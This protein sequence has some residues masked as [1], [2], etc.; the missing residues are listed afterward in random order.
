MSFRVY[1]CCSFVVLF[2]WVS[3]AHDFPTT[4]LQMLLLA[5]D[6]CYTDAGTTAASD[7]QSV[8]RWADLSGNS[9]HA[10]QS[11]SSL[12]PVWRETWWNSRPA[13]EFDGTDDILEVTS[14]TTLNPATSEFH[15]YVCYFNEDWDSTVYLVSKGNYGS[16]LDEG[17]AIYT[18]AISGENVYRVNSTGDS[19]GRAAQKTTSRIA[20]G[21]FVAELHIASGAVTATHYPAL[22]MIDGGGG[23]TG[24][25]FAGSI[26]NSDSV[27]IGG[28]LL[29]GML[30]VV[31]VY[32]GAHDQAAVRAALAGYCQMSEATSA[33]GTAAKVF[34]T[35][36]STGPWYRIPTILQAANGDLLAFAER[37]NT[38][39]DD[40][41]NNDI[42]LSVSD[43]NGAT[44][45]ALS[46]LV[47]NGT[48]RA[49]DP[50]PI[51]GADGTVYLLYAKGPSAATSDETWIITSDDN[52][53]TWSSEV[54][55]TADLKYAG[56]DKVTP[57]PSTGLCLTS[58]R[59]VFACRTR[60]SDRATQENRTFAAYSDDS[61]STWAAGYVLDLDGS[62]E[63]VIAPLTDDTLIMH[64][65]VEGDNAQPWQAW[66]LS[67]DEGNSW[68]FLRLAHTLPTNRVNTGLASITRTLVRTG[69]AT[70]GTAYSNS[71]RRDL[72]VYTS[73][74]GEIWDRRSYIQNGP[75][76]YS[77]VIE[78]ADNTAG[79]LY[80]GDDD[81]GTVAG[82]YDIFY[83]T[84]TIIP[85]AAVATGGGTPAQFT[86]GF[87]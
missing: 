23:A 77:Q 19:S 64:A 6:G 34:D 30:S 59:L 8:Y 49:A 57:L 78:V 73:P 60:D 48:D 17:W 14:S 20:G 33:V 70:R 42:V 40:L 44:W 15:V 68:Q 27:R 5:D 52:G 65:R 63:S 25:T 37:R 31:A 66:S 1:L 87:N 84:A 16:S 4:N 18:S 22:T 51:L 43:D 41:G 28:G 83:R 53:A 32:K 50:C 46:V 7:G 38:S 3:F 71:D 13:V 86:G 67:F 62:N 39:N 80:E 74:T 12:R 29:D 72:F 36:T 55:I 35:T 45:G 75:I 56:W 21:P 76:G 24:A 54:E 82:E 10:N 9:N 26:D 61:G 85:N 79:I 2:S 58:G 81:G 69:T 47:D 11:T